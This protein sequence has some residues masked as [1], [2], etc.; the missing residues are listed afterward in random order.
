MH[1]S[2]FLDC[3]RCSQFSSFFL[4]LFCLLDS[5]LLFLSLIMLLSQRA[6]SLFVGLLTDILGFIFPILKV[7]PNFAWQIKLTRLYLSIKFSNNIKFHLDLLQTHWFFEVSHK[8][9]LTHH[10]VFLD[11]QVV[12]IYLLVQ[13]F[14]HLYFSFNSIDQNLIL[15]KSRENEVTNSHT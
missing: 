8:A 7:W 13:D 5:V 10:A 9:F 14:L 2:H 4:H 3:Q 12:F 6:H 15:S 11:L 1:A